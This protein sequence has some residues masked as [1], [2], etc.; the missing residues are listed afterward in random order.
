MIGQAQAAD[1]EVNNVDV[2]QRTDGSRLV[3]IEYSVTNSEGGLLAIAVSISADSGQSWT[4]PVLGM[5]GD[6]GQGIEP[7]DDKSIIWDLN[8]YGP[9]IV[10]EGFRV[11]ISASDTGIVPSTHSPDNYWIMEWSSVDWSDCANIEKIAKGDVAV[12][13]AYSL[14]SNPANAQIDVVDQIKAINPDIVLLGYYLAKTNM[15]WWGGSTPG[16]ITNDLYVRTKPYWSYTTTGDTLMN[17]PGQVV[18][19]VL[20]P[21][22]R[23]AIAGTLAEHQQM[24]NNPLDGVLWDYFDTSVWIHPWVEDT[25]EGEVDFD[26]DGIPL[27]DDPDERVAYLAACDSLVLLTRELL[28][29]GFIQVFNGTRAQKDRDFSALGDGMYYEIFPTQ[30]FPDPDMRYALDPAYENSLFNTVHWPRTENGG[31][32]IVIGTYWHSFYMNSDGQATEIKYGNMYRAA[33]LL[34]DVYVCWLQTTQHKY[35]WTDNEISLGQPIGDT[36]IEG[37]HLYRLFQ[38]G[39]VD[40]N[41]GTGAYP[42]PYSYKITAGGVVVE[43]FDLPYYYP[44]E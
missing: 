12:L 40:L 41:L 43:E 44:E 29:D 21:D 37:D 22:C 33:A 28:G 17:W 26:A 31:P 35:D 8:S 2:A 20:D 32:Y 6:V 24:T 14:W 16:T 27:Q 42:N 15:L 36:I 39:R 18:L 30:V 1:P 11:R 23:Q 19:N 34:T 10:G 38:H 9:E 13:G 7:G 5:T 4:F 3:D 25:V